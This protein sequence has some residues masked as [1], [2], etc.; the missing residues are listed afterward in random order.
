[1]LQVL[2]WVISAQ[3]SCK[4]PL[5]GPL[6]APLLWY[7]CLLLHQSRCFLGD[8]S[9]TTRHSKC[10]YTTATKTVAADITVSI[11]T[12]IFTEA[13]LK[14]LLKANFFEWCCDM[15]WL[16]LLGTVSKFLFHTYLL[17]AM[18][19]KPTRR[20]ITSAW[21]DDPSGWLQSYTGCHISRQCHLPPVTDSRRVSLCNAAFTY[22]LFAHVT[23]CLVAFLLYITYHH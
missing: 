10:T 12:M 23:N 4:L 20:A 13:C 15:Y 1:M 18:L 8:V 7:Y 9:G 14:H 11:C 2:A 17:K 22:L 16:L 3:Y 6:P 5:T 19:H 21:P